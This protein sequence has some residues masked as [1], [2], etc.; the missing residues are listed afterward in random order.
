MLYVAPTSQSLVLTDLSTRDTYLHRSFASLM[1]YKY[2]EVR[3]PLGDQDIEVVATTD[4]NKYTTN[5]QPI[6]GWRVHLL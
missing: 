4:D 3:H 5:L 6:L 2:N 1:S